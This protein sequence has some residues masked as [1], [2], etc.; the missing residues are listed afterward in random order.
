MDELANREHCPSEPVLADVVQRPLE[1][2]SIAGA[3]SVR[4]DTLGRGK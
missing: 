3:T 1:K 2:L 4:I